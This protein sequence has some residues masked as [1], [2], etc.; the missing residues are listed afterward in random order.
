MTVE[1]LQYT[2]TSFN[3]WSLPPGG[4]VHLILLGIAAVLIMIRRGSDF[5]SLTPPGWIMLLAFCLGSPFLP[6]LLV[7]HIG[8]VM[9]PLFALA[10]IAVA[11]LLLGTGPAIVVGFLTGLGWMLI[12]GMPRLSL[13][14]EIA[15]LAG[16]VAALI[17][18]PYN[19]ITPRLIRQ[20]I[21]ALLLGTILVGW[22][23]GLMSIYLNDVNSALTSLERTISQTVPLL[24][25]ELAAALIAGLLA[26]GLAWRFASATQT[27]DRERTD[28]APWER[29][30]SRVLLSIV[31]PL[32]T[33]A[34]L[35]MGTITVTT[36]HT[37]ATRMTVEEMDRAAQDAVRNLPIFIEAG[38]RLLTDAARRDDGQSSLPFFDTLLVW[39]DEE[40]RLN[41]IERD[42][43]AAAQTGPT[44]PAISLDGQGRPMMSFI[45]MGAGQQILIGR[46]HL[47]DNLL[48]QPV[49]D[50]L[51]RGQQAHQTSYLLDADYRI[52]L[53]PVG[54][55]GEIVF[56]LEAARPVAAAEGVL[57]Q[58]FRLTTTDGTREMV[59]LYPVSGTPWQITV[60]TPNEIVL[61]H[62][63]Q[64]AV[65]I[66]VVLVILAALSLPLVVAIADR[67]T[68]PLDDLLEGARLI[69]QGQL[70]RPIFIKGNDEIGQLGDAFE[71]MRV[72]LKRRIN[73]QEKLLNVTRSVSSTLELFRAMPPILSSAMDITSAGGARIVLRKN[74]NGAHQTYAAGEIAAAMAP[75]D[76]QII[77]LVERQGTLVIS[78]IERASSTLDLVNIS[79][80]IQSIVA[81]PLRADT[82]FHGVL[83]LAYPEQH[84]F[85]QSELNFLATLAAQAAVSVT[86]VRLYNQAE[87]RRREL[88]AI[89]ESTADGLIVVDA[90]GRV[91]LMN[92][93][94]RHLLDVPP[95]KVTNLNAREIFDNEDLLALLTDLRQPANTVEIIG[96]NRKTLLANTSVITSLDGGATG[97]VAVIRD[98]TAL[99]DLDNFKTVFLRMVS[100]D[101]RSPLT[102]IGGYLTMLPMTGTLNERQQEAINKMKIG[103]NEI[104]DLTERLTHMSRME[105]GD[106]PSLDLSLLTFSELLNHILDQ[107]SSRA[108]DR[109]LSITQEIADDV[110]PF[111]A[112]RM[113]Y[114]QALSNLIGN[115][116]KYT[117]PEGEI[118]IEA[119]VE[120]EQLVVSVRDNGPGIRV[121]DQARLFEVFYRVPH[122]EGDPPAPGGSGIG[123]ALVRSIA[124]A[125]NGSVSVESEF[126][127]GSTFILRIPIKKTHR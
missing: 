37:V 92:P 56:S 72:R 19:G 16:G 8:E 74:S 24:T 50:S 76:R 49:I 116:I 107:Y 42:L 11:A 125:H 38:N 53:N 33:L 127:N 122:R 117:Q 93:A 14:F 66:L 52:L 121:E 3:L 64:I 54:D 43:I 34:V 108:R 105:F 23:L 30:L 124:D 68:K 83:W 120:D 90:N 21:M 110:P 103:V 15:L 79:S 40:T 89:L 48:M 65:P 5:P 106:Q 47:E 95:D 96:D 99:K 20:P 111:Y 82:V 119:C 109:S 25:G 69:A 6:G 61:Q 9:L 51:L 114:R 70:D 104:T 112:D 45:S 10:F 63:I 7:V 113:L 46:T 118:H 12:G 44:T 31:L 85:E 126:G 17:N 115:A 13:P 75:L 100:H 123:L 84:T 60:M 97:R 39:P 71:Q 41:S 77:D 91:I 102:Y 59:Y 22:P 78:Q 28:P 29:R 88:E 62:A 27:E 32:L 58:V 26:Q 55:E 67:I 18:Q 98:V 2:I 4:V 94:A 101:L 81:L 73:E 1:W 87:E 57:G 80:R 86:N 36:A 35:L